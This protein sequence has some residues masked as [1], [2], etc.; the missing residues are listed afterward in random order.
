MECYAVGAT[1]KEIDFKQRI[2]FFIEWA[3]LRLATAAGQPVHACP[4][5]P[6]R[7]DD[8]WQHRF[9]DWQR[10]F[11]RAGP[12]APA[13]LDDLARRVARLVDFWRAGQHEPQW[14]FPA[15]SWA[16]VHGGPEKARERWLGTRNAKGER[17]YAPGYARLL[18][19]ERDFA[20]GADLAA[21]L[22][23]AQRLGS[24]IDLQRPIMEQP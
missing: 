8:G 10:S 19:G 9:D 18:A 11:E 24:L 3:L 22:R 7:C 13:M 21:L 20:E 6:A 5:V 16:I 1:R 12:T 17:D 4:I 2:P 23:N 14:Y 15:T